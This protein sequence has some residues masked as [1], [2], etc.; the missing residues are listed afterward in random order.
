[1]LGDLDYGL[2]NMFVC[3]SAKDAK[4]GVAVDI[5]VNDINFPDAHISW[6][7]TGPCGWVG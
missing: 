2:M 1:M 3:T 4:I 5:D 7:G 6:V